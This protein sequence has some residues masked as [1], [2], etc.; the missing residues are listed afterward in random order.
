MRAG[1]FAKK[2][3]YTLVMFPKFQFELQYS[4]LDG[5]S[6]VLPEMGMKVVCLP[7]SLARLTESPNDLVVSNV[8]HKTFVDVNEEGTEAV[9]A[10]AVVEDS[11]VPPMFIADRPFRFALVHKSTNTARNFRRQGA[12]HAG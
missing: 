11:S 3:T 8:V 1:S 5:G 4:L 9:G 2:P 7:G 6:G 12:K 10:T